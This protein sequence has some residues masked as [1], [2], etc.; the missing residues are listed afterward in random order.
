MKF[1]TWNKV[2]GIY[3]GY[4]NAAPIPYRAFP[5]RSY[6]VRNGDSGQIVYIIQAMLD[7]LSAKYDNMPRVEVGGNYT[8]QTAAAIRDFQHIVGLPQNGI[9]D[10]GT[11][12][13]LVRTSEST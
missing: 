6:T 8:P 7:A 12:N 3:R 5:S 10:S 13:L 4:I 11:W 1:K 2:V 9:V